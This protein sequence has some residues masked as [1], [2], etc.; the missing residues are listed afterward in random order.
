M[1]NSRAI[2]RYFLEMRLW[3]NATHSSAVQYNQVSPISLGV[4][5]SAPFFSKERGYGLA[6]S[7]PRVQ[8]GCSATELQAQAMF[9][10]IFSLL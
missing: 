2:L 7:A 9:S 8:G 3:M 5:D 1:R 4:N 10:S 6:P